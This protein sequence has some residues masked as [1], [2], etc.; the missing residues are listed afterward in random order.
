MKWGGRR[1]RKSY[2]I[3]REIKQ[4]AVKNILSWKT[5]PWFMTQDRGGGRRCGCHNLQDK[6]GRQDGVTGM[7]LSVHFGSNAPAAPGAASP[8]AA[9]P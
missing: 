7:Q 8:R 6:A 2:G 5:E 9:P 3:K 4:G 1:G